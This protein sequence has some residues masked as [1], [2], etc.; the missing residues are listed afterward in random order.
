MDGNVDINLLLDFYGPL[1]DDRHRQT[2]EMYFGDDM[3]LREIAEEI[4]VSRQAVQQS[5]AKGRA[6]L[7]TFEEK[8]GLCGRFRAAEEKFSEVKKL[9]GEIKS[10]AGEG[11]VADLCDR[12]AGAAD[13]LIANF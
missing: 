8:L 10:K 2:L 4:G 7:E 12:L 13:D 11:P 5:V 6:D 3:S 9:A 1:L